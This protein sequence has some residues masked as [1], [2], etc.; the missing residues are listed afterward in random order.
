MTNTKSDHPCNG[1]AFYQGSVWQPANAAGLSALK[2]GFARKDLAAEQALYAQDDE[3]RGVFCVSSG[4]IAVRTHHSDGTSTLI[5]LAYPGDIIGYR[6]FLAGAR[7]KTEARA[8]VPSRVCIVAHR[9]V[10]HVIGANPTVL[11]RIAGRCV[12]EIDSNHARIIATSVKPNRDRLRDLLLELMERHGHRDGDRLSMH[13]PLS[14]TDLADLIGVR[15]ETM[16]RLF[17]Q[18]KDDGTLTVSGREIGM[19]V[20]APSR[21]PE[22]GLLPR[23]HS[24]SRDTRRSSRVATA[25]RDHGHPAIPT[26]R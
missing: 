10:S 8:L 12:T 7:H 2:R 4:L 3:N 26:D 1:C 11:R 18:L 25:V 22:A 13:L 24:Q 20:T 19:A 15:P 21:P 14:R 16:S 9:D 6:S 17:R 23:R 5:K